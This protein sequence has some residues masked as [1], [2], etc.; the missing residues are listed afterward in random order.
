MAV[1]ARCAKVSALDA[2]YHSKAVVG[3][4][5]VGGKKKNKSKSQ[6]RLRQMAWA[7]PPVP[8]RRSQYTQA[9]P[10]TTAYYSQP[11]P[12]VPARPAPVVPV[13]DGLIRVRALYDFGG[14]ADGDLVFRKGDII[15]VTQ[16]LA[17]GWWEGAS[18][19]T[20]IG[21]SCVLH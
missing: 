13:D 19:C 9:P 16:K 4:E 11:P 2:I 18:Y 7:P 5:E 3:W 6:S 15:I 20:Q 1:T 12:P 8:T 14:T 10:A 17:P 21:C